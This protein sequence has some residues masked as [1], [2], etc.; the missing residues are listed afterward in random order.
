MVKLGPHDGVHGDRVAGLALVWRPPDS[1]AAPFEVST[2]SVAALRPAILR[3]SVATRQIRSRIGDEGNVRK[4]ALIEVPHVNA[5]VP[6]TSC[7]IDP[8]GDNAAFAAA[9]EVEC[10]RASAVGLSRPFDRCRASRIVTPARANA[11]AVVTRTFV[12]FLRK[13]RYGDRYPSA[14]ALTSYHQSASHDVRFF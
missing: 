4:D 3:R 6:D 12:Y 5:H 14:I 13:L 10:L 1:P 7:W 11:R 2:G 8:V 9:M